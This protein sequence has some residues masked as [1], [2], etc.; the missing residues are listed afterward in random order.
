MNI[1]VHQMVILYVSSTPKL[2]DAKTSVFEE[3]MPGDTKR[4]LLK[5]EDFSSCD[6]RQED[7]SQS[8]NP[9]RVGRRYNAFGQTI[10]P[11]TQLDRHCLQLSAHMVRFVAQ[12]QRPTDH[13]S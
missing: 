10:L 6:F 1:V 7:I 8:I 9:D 2:G 5:V 4:S 12:K 13:V 3:Y 11:L